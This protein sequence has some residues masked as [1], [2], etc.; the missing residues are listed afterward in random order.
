MYIPALCNSQNMVKIKQEN[1]S[2]LDKLDKLQ[3]NSNTTIKKSGWGI[4]WWSSGQDSVHCWGLGSIPDQG[5]KIPQAVQC[6][7]KK[8]KKI[9]E[10]HWA[11]KST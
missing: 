1:M 3:D 4:P 11:G 9:K 10:K 8:K 5:T 7:K 2:K 6:G